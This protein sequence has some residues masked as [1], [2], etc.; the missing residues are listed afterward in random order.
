MHQETSALAK[1]SIDIPA[2]KKP[3]SSSSSGTSLKHM[4]QVKVEITKR[5]GS[6]MTPSRSAVLSITK[7]PTI[8]EGKMLS[9]DPGTSQQTIKKHTAQATGKPDSLVVSALKV[10]CC[11]IGVKSHL[12]EEDKEE[13]GLRHHSTS[14]MCDQPNDDVVH[15]MCGSDIDEGF[16]IQVL[17]SGT[18]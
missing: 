4:K 17:R 13:K 7:G 3:S 18:V 1:E 14:S 11:C 6:H 5:Q 12:P 8:L 15:C 10:M 2:G 9:R 16:M